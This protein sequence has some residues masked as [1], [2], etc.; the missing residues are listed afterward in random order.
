MNND[1]RWVVF[2]RIWFDWT[3][4][5]WY[6]YPLDHA[7]VG[8]GVERERLTDLAAGEIIGESDLLLHK[9][10]FRVTQMLGEG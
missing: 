4:D 3:T 8:C 7:F 5:G 9:A 2:D 1:T 6:W 10:G